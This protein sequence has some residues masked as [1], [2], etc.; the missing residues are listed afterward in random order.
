MSALWVM[1][2]AT[3]WRSTSTRWSRPTALHAVGPE[4]DEVGGA[5]GERDRL[6]AGGPA[7]ERTAD[8]VAVGERQADL[9]RGRA[10]SRRARTP[11]GLREVL[12]RGREDPDALRVLE[13]EVTRGRSIG[14]VTAMAAFTPNVGGE[15][16]GVDAL[17]VV[18][19]HQAS[20]AR[21]RR[22]LGSRG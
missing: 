13:P 4:Q 17:P 15:R 6:L 3:L 9:T 20:D 11:A 18:V 22:V 21:R 19:V 5:L 16:D 1:R 12:R 10:R 8:V 2:S 7:R 14:A